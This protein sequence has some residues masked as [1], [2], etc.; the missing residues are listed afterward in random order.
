MRSRVLVRDIIFSW[1]N[2]KRESI[3][4]S[5]DVERDLQRYGIVKFRQ[6]HNS[7]TYLRE[8]RKIRKNN[9]LLSQNGLSIR[10]LRKGKV[11]GWIIGT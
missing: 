5:Y 11:K 9:S 1:L 2:T 6:I 4:Y 10:E 3:F 8:W 7:E